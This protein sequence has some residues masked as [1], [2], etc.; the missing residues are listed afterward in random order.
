MASMPP[1]TDPGMAGLVTPSSNAQLDELLRRLPP[2]NSGWQTIRTE[3]T[4]PAGVIPLCGLIAGC[5]IGGITLYNA[6]DVSAK[7]NLRQDALLEA[8]TTTLAQITR[9]NERQGDR[10]DVAESKQREELLAWREWRK[11]VDESL[12]DARDVSL[13]VAQNKTRAEALDTRIS[14][15]VELFQQMGKETNAKLERILIEQAEVK[16]RLEARSREQTPP[17]DENRTLKGVLRPPFLRAMLG[18][19][20]RPTIPLLRE[21]SAARFHLSDK[22]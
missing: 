11:T 9:Q 13:E 8:Q 22:Q 14:R 2:Q 5:V 21:I 19:N 15:V 4:K 1:L 20:A 3:W 7:A 10:A 6:V 16:A 12:R 17:F 18:R